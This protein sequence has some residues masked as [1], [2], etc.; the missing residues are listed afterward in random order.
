MTAN[1]SF[2]VHELLQ[3]RTSLQQQESELRQVIEKSEREVRALGELGTADAGDLSYGNSLKESMFAHIS[4]VRRQLRLVEYALKRI[5][6]GEFGV[7][8]G[9]EDAISLKRLQAVPWTRH[10]RECQERFEHVQR[11][12]AMVALYC[13]NAVQV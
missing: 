4:Q 6:S 11:H 9:C 10:C 2:D 5:R 8:S 3:F 12:A 1:S 13:R 7:C